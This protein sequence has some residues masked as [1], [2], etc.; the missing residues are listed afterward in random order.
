MIHLGV[1][2]GPGYPLQVFISLRFIPGFSLLSLTRC[3][4]HNLS[5]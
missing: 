1:T 2:F 4:N 3:L 5:D